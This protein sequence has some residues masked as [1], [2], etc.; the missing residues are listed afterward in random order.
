MK[1]LARGSVIFSLVTLIG[2]LFY[3]QSTAIAEDTFSIANDSTRNV[4]LDQIQEN[5]NQINTQQNNKEENI[6]EP[7]LNNSINSSVLSEGRSFRAT[8]YCL[9]GRTATGGSVRRGIVAA[10]RRVLPLGT[11]IQISAGA[12]SGIYTVTDTGGAV[13]G[14]TIDIWVPS[15]SEANRFGRRTVLVSVVGKK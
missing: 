5:N 14:R 10:D 11:R 13:K 3:F 2:F 4:Q 15:C 8:A 1:N 6:I 9:K 12:Y 7:I